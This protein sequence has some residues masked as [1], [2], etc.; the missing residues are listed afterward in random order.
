MSTQHEVV[1]KVYRIPAALDQKTSECRKQKM[2]WK[3][4]LFLTKFLKHRKK[5]LLK[6]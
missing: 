3:R 5:E 2:I 6:R 4:K 1:D